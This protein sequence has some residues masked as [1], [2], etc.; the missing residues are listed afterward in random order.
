MAEQRDERASVSPVRIGDVARAAGVS[1]GTV[2]KALNDRP[3]VSAATRE[4]VRAVAE[5]LSFRPNPQARSLSTGRSF[6]VGLLTTDIY[7]RFSLPLLLGAEDELGDGDLAVIRSAR[8]GSC[9][10]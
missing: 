1:V 6:A 9:T 10:P 7:G 2:S 4:R 5:R 3:D 8:S